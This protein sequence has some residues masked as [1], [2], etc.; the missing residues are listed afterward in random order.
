ML[1]F[2]PAVAR[3]AQL[4]YAPIAAA[5]EQLATAPSPEPIEWNLIGSRS[6]T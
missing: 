2:G 1:A 4:E 5:F 6:D 3:V